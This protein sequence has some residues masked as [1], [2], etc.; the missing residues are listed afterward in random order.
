MISLIAVLLL[1]AG[2]QSK[3]SVS[4]S[5]PVDA[6]ST[7]AKEIES[8]LTPAAREKLKAAVSPVKTAPNTET[9]ARQAVTKAFSDAALGDADIAILSFYVIAEA[10]ATTQN[11]MK[12]ITDEIDK[13]SD[14]KTNVQKELQGT[15]LPA[16]SISK[17]Q[18][19]AP[20]DFY[21]AP[22]ALPKGAPVEQLMQRLNELGA[23]SESNQVKVQNLMSQKSR[24]DAILSS[25]LIK[26]SA[27][28]LSTVQNLK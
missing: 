16:L 15:D 7:K 28:D 5:A 18:P 21:R 2:P 25:L 27:A 11:D 3:V 20:K 26:M 12:S 13:M 9:A 6:V 10:S 1:A 8:K 24:F 17:V 4:R 22:A 14:Q 19:I 23:M